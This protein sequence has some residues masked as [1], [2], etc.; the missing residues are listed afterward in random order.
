MLSGG[1]PSK[2]NE[3]YWKGDVPWVSCKDMKT[4][5]IFDAED[6]L[7]KEGTESGTRMVKPGTVLIVVRGMI[8]AREFPVA[9]AK[10]AVAFNQDLKALEC[11]PCL[12][13][14][15]LFYWLK[16]RTYD[17]LGMADEAAHGTKRLQTD[18]LQSL[19]IDLPPRPVQAAI[20]SVLSAYDDLIENNT[21]R[22]KI[23]EQMAEMIYREWFVNFRL[24][25][26]EKLRT[27]DSELGPIPAGWAVANLETVCQR[28]T[29]GSHWSPPTVGS[30]YRMASSKD[31]HRWGLDLSSAR[32]ISKE[33]FDSLIRNDCKPL[34]GDILITKDGANYLK[35]CFVI[36]K[37]I[38]A[39][40]LS[41]IAMVR[42]DPERMRP[43]LLAFYLTDPSVKT[44]LAGR[45]SGAAIPRIVLKDF[46]QFAVLVPPMAIQAAFERIAA[47]IV[48][49]CWRLTDKNSNLR[50][51]RDLLLSKLISG[52][53]PVG[54]ADDAAAELMEY[55][56]QPA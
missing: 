13:D 14:Q 17:I 41:S 37:D 42:P 32:T 1:T 6:H 44:R 24:P 51:T 25:G 2:A 36:E 27:V 40:L 22:I 35:F 9:V 33:D 16:A 15:Y 29:D 39:V 3:S 31:M 38:D 5:R 10:R 54:A 55:E 19:E 23:L 48:G 47:P 56:E 4:E 45:V 12:N 50:T 21:R 18:R 26:H 43:H 34:A 46:R 30:T 53:I 7:S 52:E 8:L 28:I 20:V 49:L 11:A